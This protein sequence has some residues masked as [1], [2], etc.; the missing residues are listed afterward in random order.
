[1]SFCSKCGEKISEGNSFC[2]KCG[3]PSQN[4]VES[5][6]KQNVQNS[7]QPNYNESKPVKPDNFLVWGILTTILC[8]LPFGIVSIVY[9]SKVDGLYHNGQFDDAKNAASNAKTWAIVSASIG[10]VFAIIYVLAMAAAG[11]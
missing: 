9:A 3:T 4:S 6:T 8:C 2:S 11:L 1:M 7:S 10:F 5:Q